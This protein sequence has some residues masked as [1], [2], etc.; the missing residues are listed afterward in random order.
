MM[1]RFARQKEPWHLEVSFVEP[2]DP[3]ITSSKYLA[4]Y[5]PAKIPVSRSFYD[6]FEG[7]PG[8]HRRE[9]RNWGE[10]TE[11]DY[12]Q[13]RVHYYA[14]CEQLDTQ[15][16]RLLEELDRTGQA[17][18]TLVTFSTDHGDMVGNHHM[19][20]K[21]WMPYEE[22]YRI[23]IVMRWP[24]RIRP[25]LVSP[26]LVQ[27]HDLADTY[28]DAAGTAP[29]QYRGGRSLLPLTRDPGRRDWPD[30]ILCAYYGGEFLY[31][32][33]M[34]ITE[35]YKYVFNGFDFDECYDLETD[36]EE[37][38]NCVEDGAYADVVDDLRAR[39]Y[40]LMNQL[41][42]PYGDVGPGLPDKSVPIMYAAGRYLPRGKPR[43]QQP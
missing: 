4:H 34:V 6:T 39:L 27:L 5:D 12:R 11:D 3:Y 18:N 29:L 35:R 23:P 42:D 33:R 2:H 17:E 19:W 31:T 8:M 20:I 16:G 38:H 36:P 7:K 22:C 13:G 14:Y 43:V 40:G 25:G 1:R 24:A 41:G 30:Q 9:S 37:M 32:Q 21:E 26:R 15:I 10:V 28:L